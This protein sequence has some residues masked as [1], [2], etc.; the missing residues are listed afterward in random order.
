[1]KH[2][3]ARRP[4][5]LDSTGRRRRTIRRTGAFLAVPTV[6]YLVLMAS[7]L[8]GGPRMDTPLIPLPEAAKPKHR[9]TAPPAEIA[10]ETPR[11]TNTSGTPGDEPSST[12]QT[13]STTPTGGPTSSPTTVPT[14]IPP[15]TPVPPPTVVP[16]T[17][18]TTTTTTPPGRTNSPTTA[19]TPTATATHGNKPTTPPGKT[20]TPTAP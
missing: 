2:H 12:A 11:P 17:A 14:S 4:V 6:G 3:S 7:S 15:V 10:I 8:L 5:F 13:P 18:P 19:P 9:P 16:T 1:M 20:K